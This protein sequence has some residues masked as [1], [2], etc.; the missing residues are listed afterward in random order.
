MRALLLAMP[1]C[2]AVV[3]TTA[4]AESVGEVNTAFRW[5]GK[6]D[7]IVVEA[8]DDP[9]VQGVTCYVSRARTGGVKGYRRIGRG[10]ERGFHRLPPSGRLCPV[11]GSASIQ[12]DVFTERMSQRDRGG[13][14][15]VESACAVVDNSGLRAGGPRIRFQLCTGRSHQSARGRKYSWIGVG[16]TKRRTRRE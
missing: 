6:D 4:G 8:Y 5:L 2:M 13:R 11:H 15:A 12:E 16:R 14:A 1:L 10:Q 7:R 3:C 9:K